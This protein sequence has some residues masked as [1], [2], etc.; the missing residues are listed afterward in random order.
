M[1]IYHDY[2]VPTNQGIFFKF[3]EGKEV[4]LRLQ[5]E[6]V[7]FD[8]VFKSTGQVSTK[9]AYVMYNYDA[10]QA[11][12]LQIPGGVF[13]TIQSFARDTEYGDPQEYDFKMTRS[14]TG[15]DTKYE[16]KPSP[17]K[18]KLEDVVPGAT[19]KVLEVD[20]IE[21]LSKSESNQNVQFLE[22]FLKGGSPAPGNVK[23]EE[24]TD[25]DEAVEDGDW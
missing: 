9:Y 24:P 3:E 22:D 15:L 12:I 20:I 19:E 17:K 11:Q 13:K 16:V 18:T 7:I 2:E 23:T 1:S 8:S 21:A 6:P 14:G 4:R 25:G 10:E 5:S